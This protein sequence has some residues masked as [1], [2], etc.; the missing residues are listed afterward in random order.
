MSGEKKRPKIS[1]GAA[2]QVKATVLHGVGYKRPPEHSRFAKG[3]SGNP[4]GRPRAPKNHGLS[5]QDQPL[6]RA[7]YEQAA[8]PIKLREG[9]IVIEVSGREALAQ[10]ILVTAYKGNARSQGLAIDLIR[11]ADIQH[12]VD[13]AER[14]ELAESYKVFKTEEIAKAIRDGEDTRL[15]LPHPDDVVLDDVQGFRIVGP[16]DERELLKIEELVRVRDVLILQYVLDERRS[17]DR[18]SDKPTTGPDDGS[19]SGALVFAMFI[20]NLLPLR[21]R[22][23]DWG[24]L[25]KQM[26]HD[27]S[28]LRELLKEAYAAWNSLGRGVKRGARFA[29]RNTTVRSLEFTMGLYEAIEDGRINP[30]E[31]ARGQFSDE[32]FDL[33]ERY[34]C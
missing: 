20:N 24:F 32:A 13:R 10:S 19:E 1:D 31:M 29:D 17:N 7:V 3:Q 11:S 30:D 6:L 12:A 28:T 21:F 16:I 22:L 33:V 34:G 23:D 14:Q 5:L 25:H 4:K 15:I 9:D 26:A 2:N 8:K 27:R 18:D